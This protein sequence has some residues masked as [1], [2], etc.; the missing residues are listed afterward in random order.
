MHVPGGRI[1]QFQLAIR[2]NRVWMP[3]GVTQNL[4][5][6]SEMLL[7]NCEVCVHA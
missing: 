4:D 6:A 2:R 5:L 3:V 7:D 1:G